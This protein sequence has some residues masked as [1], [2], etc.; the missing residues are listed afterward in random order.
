MLG[1]NLWSD[2]LATNS[3]KKNEPPRAIG[4]AINLRG[5][6]GHHSKGINHAVFYF[7]VFIC[8]ISTE[9]DSACNQCNNQSPQSRESMGF[10]GR[11]VGFV[12]FLM[13]VVFVGLHGFVLVVFVC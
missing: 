7:K 2:L 13:M 10:H 3:I 6:S 11:F 9:F 1:P 5:D 8:P 4:Q 12:Q